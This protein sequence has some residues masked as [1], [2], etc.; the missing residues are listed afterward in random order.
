MYFSYDKILSKD[1]DLYPINEA[2]WKVETWR[3]DLVDIISAIEKYNPSLNLDGIKEQVNL[4]YDY[5]NNNDCLFDE[6]TRPY[7]HIKT[8]IL[9][10]RFSSESAACYVEE[11]GSILSQFFSIEL[12]KK[13]IEELYI[14]H[15]YG[16][17]KYVVTEYSL[18]KKVIYKLTDNKI[19]I[20]IKEY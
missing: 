8:R 15:K 18:N 9:K 4:I 12:A 11:N 14:K 5:Y 2:D 17:V 20:I 3:V 6:V 19:E 7:P 1:E 10:D 16:N 13:Y